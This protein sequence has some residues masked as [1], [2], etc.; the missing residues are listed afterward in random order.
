MQHSLKEAKRLGHNKGVGMSE[1]HPGEMRRKYH[2]FLFKETEV[3]GMWAR[4]AWGLLG[5]IHEGFFSSAAMMKRKLSWWRRQSGYSRVIK[6]M[7]K[8]V[9]RLTHG[10]TASNSAAD[11]VSP[12]LGSGL[13]SFEESGVSLT[14]KI[15]VERSISPTSI[16]SKD[17]DLFCVYPG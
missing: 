15:K 3:E 4:R 17:P 8:T 14:E 1:I 5:Q 10:G 16:K 7:K 11:A 6:Q 13:C 9:K 12:A 2:S